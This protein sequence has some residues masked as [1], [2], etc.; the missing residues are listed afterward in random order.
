M[1]STIF[2]MIEHLHHLY[3][4]SVQTMCH[5]FHVSKSSYYAFKSHK[6][7]QRD[8]ENEML[9]KEIMTSYLASAKRY[10]APKIHKDLLAKGYRVSIKRVQKLM[11]TLTIHSIV[12]KK[13]RPVLS[14]KKEGK[15]YP[16]LLKRDFS[17]DKVNEKWVTDIT[18]IYTL[19][20]GWCYL[21]SILDLHSR[22]IIAWRLAKK[23][24]TRLVIETLKDALSTRS[25]RD[26]LILHSDRGSQYTSKEYNDFLQK[27]GIQHSYSAKGCPYDNSC[28][29]SFHATIKK[30][31]ISVETNVGYKDYQSCYSS[32]FKYI[33]GFYNSR[34]RHSKLNYLCPNDFEKQ[35]A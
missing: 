12:R 32:I 6:P 15:E 13:Y 22:K 10:G 35:I 23:M 28:I 33:E 34:R 8:K 29:E 19:S 14:T 31:C 17:T 26:E 2:Q 24:E 18:Y 3:Q 11:K 21:S 1:N 27:H 5:L 30:E 20:D 16:N 9:K 4:F 25:V 7:S